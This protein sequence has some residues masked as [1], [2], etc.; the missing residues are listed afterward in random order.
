MK[1]A[2]ELI[3][4]ARRIE[5]TSRK[6]VN[7]LFRG[8][9]SSA[10]KGRGI[11]F[12]EV[13]EYQAGD[14]IRD[15]DWNVTSRMDRPYI[16]VNHEE[17]ELSVVLVL[18]V[19]ASMY[20]GTQGISKL[21]RLIELAAVFAISAI[22]NGDKVGAILVG[23]TL[24]A[25]IAP[26]KGKQQVMRILRALLE[27]DVNEKGTHLEKAL[28]WVAKTQKRKS[29]VVVLSDFYSK[30]LQSSLKIVANRHQ[31]VP[32]W[33]EDPLETEWFWPNTHPTLKGLEVN[34]SGVASS[35]FIESRVIDQKDR[36]Q[37]LLDLFKTFHL[38]P[39]LIRMDEPYLSKLLKY[40][41]R[42]KQS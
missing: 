9:Y 14:D 40:F 38:R 33:L 39:L 17:R 30:N 12:S 10:F 34:E 11:E 6:I 1:D 36:H 31:V 28:E 24:Q 26:K 19:S 29:F 25:V 22:E 21:D 15:I 8:E 35:S 7:T 27:S 2:R 20:W 13:R 41:G 42:L 5:I 23:N 4:K 16:K 18:D 3:R 37:Q 32:I